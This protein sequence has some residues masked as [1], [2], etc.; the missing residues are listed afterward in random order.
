MDFLNG[1][2]SQYP[3]F[4]LLLVSLLISVLIVLMTKFFTD[5]KHMK[6]LKEEMQKL[7]KEMKSTKDTKEISKLNK[8]LLKLNSE[9][10]KHSMRVNLYTFLPIILIFSWLSN[11]YSGL[12]FEPN[13]T[14]DLV[15]SLKSA[16]LNV[17]LQVP[18]GLKLINQTKDSSKIV[19]TL[20]SE[21]EGSYELKFLPCNST[22]NLVSSTQLTNKTEPRI[23]L[24]D[25]CVKNIIVRYR[26]LKFNILG[27]KMSWFWAYILFSLFLSSIIRK[28]IKVY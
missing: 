24:N 4:F 15:V 13:T 18:E 17:S 6:Y 5:Q 21:K 23:A 14:V 2:I 8:K 11:I 16:D 22:L 19:Y 28:V 27:I 20:L 12:P 7:Q 26:P 3:L 10:M 9:Y 1:F 25:N